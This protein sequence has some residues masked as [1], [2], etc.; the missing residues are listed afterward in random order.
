MSLDLKTIGSLIQNSQGLVDQIRAD[1]IILPA[2]ADAVDAARQRLSQQ[3]AV[4]AGGS[5]K[6]TF[7]DAAQKTILGKVADL[8]QQIED[9]D[10]A[11]D[12]ALKGILLGDISIQYLAL[13]NTGTP[14]I[15][16]IIALSA[17]DT[18]QIAALVNAA[19]LDAAKRQ[20]IADVLGAA[21]S[22]TKAALKIATSAVA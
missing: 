13:A 20:Q 14:G 19:N 1:L 8:Q 9:A 22:L 11:G 4:A 15:G 10:A 21:V 12:G 5:L 17:A 7:A 6:V 18:A 16:N 3:T 2:A